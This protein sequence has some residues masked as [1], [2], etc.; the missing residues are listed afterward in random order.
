[1]LYGGLRAGLAGALLGASLLTTVEARAGDF[2]LEVGSTAAGT[3]WRGDVAGYGSLK[4]GYRFID[5]IGLYVQGQE[6]YAIVDQRMLTLVSIGGQ[7]WGR[8]GPTRPYGRLG[9]LHQHEE[10]LSVVVD[11][12]GGA[13]FGVGDGIR[14]RF[15]GEVGVGLD[16]PFFEREKVVLYAA[17][18]GSAKIFPDE[19]GPKV[20][21]GG[22]VSFGSSFLI[23]G[24]P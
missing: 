7:V 17:I 20:Y 12:V 24:A 16:V 22:G 4:L 11:D 1:M 13:I 2:R 14:H 8:I 18:E 10:S 15:G 21:A 23:P 9:F 6:G 5:L 3:E 19:L